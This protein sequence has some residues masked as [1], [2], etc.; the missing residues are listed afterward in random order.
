[1]QLSLPCCAIAGKG[2]VCV[3]VCLTRGCDGR[4]N[5]A[6]LPSRLETGL[7]HSSGNVYMIAM[8]SF[9]PCLTLMT[10]CGP[11]CCAWDVSRLF[12]IP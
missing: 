7:A 12:T 6:G 9:L 1:M 8:C 5:I 11:V 2:A 3:C 4:V 10:L